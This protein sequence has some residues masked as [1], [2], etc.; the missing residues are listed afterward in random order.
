MFKLTCSSP[1]TQGYIY[2]QHRH[3]SHEQQPRTYLPIRISERHRAELKGYETSL[4]A[5]QV[6]EGYIKI[7]L[8]I[9]TDTLNPLSPRRRYSTGGIVCEVSAIS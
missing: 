8:T 5:L 7:P 4:G 9:G 1:T 6:H 3:S 2:H